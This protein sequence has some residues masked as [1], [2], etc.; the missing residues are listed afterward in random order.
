MSDP[1]QPH[2][3]QPTRLHCAWG[4]SKARILE[5]GCY[6]FLQ[7]IFPTQGLNPGFRHCRRILYC[8]NHQ[9]KPILECKI[10]LKKNKIKSHFT[11][12]DWVWWQLRNS[13]NHREARKDM[14]NLSF[15]RFMKWRYSCPP[16]HT[17]SL[18]ILA[19]PA[20]KLFKLVRPPRQK[21]G[22]ISTWT[23]YLHKP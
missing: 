5:W 12:R 14:C 21:P 8:L 23:R 9:G 13:M 20:H 17:S 18:G 4:F 2:G 11:E 15:K 16:Q 3:R 7:G 6:A 22:H 10:I 1:L 19:E